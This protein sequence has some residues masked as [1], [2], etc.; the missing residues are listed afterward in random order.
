MLIK[1]KDQL[2]SSEITDEKIYRNR[3]QFLKAAG[4]A[5]V[6]S[7]GGLILLPSGPEG[8]GA[9]AATLVQTG[10][11]DTSE[12]KTP[13]EDVTSY[14]NYYEFGTGKDDPARNAHTLKPRPWTVKVDGL[15]KDPKT[16]NLDDLL[17]G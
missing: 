1:K 4:I 5:T 3:R 13:Y 7:A 15:V 16:W 8:R 17:K 12:A 11:F 14:N 6:V 2:R 9:S 10:K